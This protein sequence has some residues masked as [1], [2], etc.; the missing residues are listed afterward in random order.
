MIDTIEFPFSLAEI[1]CEDN[2]T[3]FLLQRGTDEPSPRKELRNSGMFEL[4]VH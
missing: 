2:L 4:A 3:G 1:V